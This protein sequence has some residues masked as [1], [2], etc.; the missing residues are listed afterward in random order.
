M[1]LCLSPAGRLCGAICQFVLSARRALRY[2]HKDNP[3]GSLFLALA[4]ARYAPRARA[5]RIEGDKD[6]LPNILSVLSQAIKE[7]RCI[8]I[9]YYDQRQIR[10]VEPHAIYANERGELVL[11]AYQTRGFSASGR[12]PPFWR[13]FRLKKISAVSLLKETFEP[14]LTE[15]FSPNRL[16][17]KNGL[18]AIVETRSAPA[19]TYPT[20]AQ[21]IGPPR[22]EEF[23]RRV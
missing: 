16:K 15:G 11:D 23:F 18:M 20:Q 14:R 9:R 17:Y 1:S 12:R 2:S 3:S 4:K 22:P 13:P 10:V 7:K 8:A 19:F 5:K 21:E 6:M